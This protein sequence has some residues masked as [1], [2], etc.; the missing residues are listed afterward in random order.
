[1]K[2][3][4]IILKEN[5]WLS[6]EPKYGLDFGWGN[7]YIVIPKGHKLYGMHYNS[8]HDFIPQLD[9]NGG[10]TFSEFGSECKSWSEINSLDYDKWI[11]GFDTAHSWDTLEN[12]PK[13]EVER[14]TI[15]LLNQ[16]NDFIS[17]QK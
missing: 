15:D 1:M 6:R 9:C 13:E 8:I 16:I 17:N 4:R 3:D 7:G 14:L 5:T 10:L 2:L 12:K 11:V